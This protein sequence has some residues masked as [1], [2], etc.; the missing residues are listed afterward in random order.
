M[1]FDILFTIEITPAGTV[2]RSSMVICW[3]VTSDISVVPCG[4]TAR[5]ISLALDSVL[6]ATGLTPEGKDVVGT[7][8]TEGKD[9]AGASVAEDEGFLEVKNRF[10]DDDRS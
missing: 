3:R 5:S 6:W 4:T 9:A 7:F 2:S 10:T 1:Q 8:V